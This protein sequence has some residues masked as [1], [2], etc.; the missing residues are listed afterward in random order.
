MEKWKPIPNTKRKY[1]V[2]DYGRIKSNV[3][4][5][6]L[7]TRHNIRNNSVYER[8]TLSIDGKKKDFYV[9]VLVKYTFEPIEDFH[10]Y[11]VDHRSNNSLDN[12]LSNLQYL[13]KVDNLKKKIRTFDSYKLFKNLIQAYGDK[14]V[15]NKLKSINYVDSTKNSITQVI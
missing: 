1:S 12:R 2:S 5:Q 4:K 11:H 13:L 15:Y 10:L 14:I 9:H 8:V 7:K 6:I 3:T